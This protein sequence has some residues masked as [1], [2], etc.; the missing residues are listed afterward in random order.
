MA[1]PN[2]WN[3]LISAI[4]TM[5]TAGIAFV[6][7]QIIELNAFKATTESR[8]A[9]TDGQTF[10]SLNAAILTNRELYRENKDLNIRQN[11]IIAEI[12]KDVNSIN[13]NIARL[14]SRVAEYI[15]R[16]SDSPRP[17]P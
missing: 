12:R 3:I 1:A 9:T 10:A 7:V 15:S 8:L 2:L 13:I 5:L 11:E 17:G 14:E 6:L 4:V 16:Q